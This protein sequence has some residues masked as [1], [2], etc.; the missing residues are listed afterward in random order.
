M[1]V[2]SIPLNFT[3]YTNRTIDNTE[4]NIIKEFISDFVEASNHN[5]LFAISN[6]LRELENTFDSIQYVEFGKVAGEDT[7]KIFNAFEGF[8]N[9]TTSE[10]NDYVPEYL[11]IEKILK[12]DD[13]YDDGI[14]VYL[15]YDYNINVVY[16]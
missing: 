1:D 6:L 7:Q 13:T 12:Y 15:K 11:N 16:K 9:M 5:G 14:N 4:D 2:T 8:N 10:I 3:I